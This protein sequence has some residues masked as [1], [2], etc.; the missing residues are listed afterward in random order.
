MPHEYYS[1]LQ[2]ILENIKPNN[3][4]P[5]CYYISESTFNRLE[6]EIVKKA[7]RF[8]LLGTKL[9]KISR[10]GQTSEATDPD[11]LTLI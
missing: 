10:T 6:T 3:T 11:Q 4:Y 7:E 8:Y 1:D 9:T 2:G 5:I